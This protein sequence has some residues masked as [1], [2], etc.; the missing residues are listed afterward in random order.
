MIG[1]RDGQGEGWC[2]RGV[3][4]IERIAGEDGTMGLV[5]REHLIVSASVRRRRHRRFHFCGASLS[6]YPLVRQFLSEP[7]DA[8][9]KLPSPPLPLAHFGLEGRR[10]WRVKRERESAGRLN[11]LV[12]MVRDNDAEIVASAF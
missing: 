1:T 2:M 6:V 10:V 11:S 5:E 3:V 4:G 12:S 9:A 7:E 8:D